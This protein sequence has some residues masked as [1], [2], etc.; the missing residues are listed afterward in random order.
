MEGGQSLHGIAHKTCL[1]MNIDLKALLLAGLA[2]LSL[3]GFLCIPLT[4]G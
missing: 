4:Q 3:I 1:G 2:P